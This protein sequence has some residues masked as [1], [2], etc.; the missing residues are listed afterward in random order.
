MAQARSADPDLVTGRIGISGLYS[1]YHDL[2]GRANRFPET[3]EG[4]LKFL[5]RL[6]TLGDVPGNR[7]ERYRCSIGDDS[8][9][10]CFHVQVAAIFFPQSELHQANFNTGF[11]NLLYCF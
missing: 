2:N 5:L 11:P 3:F 7:L 10:S 6:L 4:L 1:G 8:G 9:S